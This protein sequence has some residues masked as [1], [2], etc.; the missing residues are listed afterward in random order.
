M[1]K[2]EGDIR[3]ED[4]LEP[5]QAEPGRFVGHLVFILTM[6]SANQGF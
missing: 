4:K 5:E 3:L 1:I 6:V 2:G